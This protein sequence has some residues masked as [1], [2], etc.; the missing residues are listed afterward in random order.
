MYD[1]EY[2]KITKYN[3]A[4][5]DKIWTGIVLLVKNNS[6]KKYYNLFINYF[7]SRSRFI[8]LFLI[9]GIMLLNIYDIINSHLFL[10]IL[11]LTGIAVTY[12]ITLQEC[13]IIV[14]F[15]EN[16]CNYSN[17]TSCSNTKQK[18]SI[19]VKNISFSQLGFV[20]FVGNSVCLL[21]VILGFITP[22]YIN[23]LYFEYQ[24]SLLFIIW[25][26]FYQL[27]ISKKICPLCMCVN[28]IL[29]VNI[30]HFISIGSVF[31]FPQIKMCICMS[32][33]YCAALLFQVV[34][35][36]NIVSKKEAYISRTNELSIKRNKQIMGRYFSN[37][38]NVKIDYLKDEFIIGNTLSELK[39]TLVLSEQCDYCMNLLKRIIP[40]MKSDLYN[41]L[42]IIRFRDADTLKTIKQP[43]PIYKLLIE[44]H[45]QDS[46]NSIIALNDWITG[47]NCADIMNRFAIKSFSERTNH[48]AVNT[49]DW[50]MNNINQF[51]TIII[52][53]KKMPEIYNIKDLPIILFGN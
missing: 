24:L 8:L 7:I 5:F 40:F 44:L 32:L 33:I 26:I 19:I 49:N 15:T 39:V 23:L 9:G 21:L 34:I 29:I 2:N 17:Y 42:W 53:D 47:D 14:N 48:I 37:Q 41:A 36:A 52:N 10:L 28:F 20:F 45:R 12:I 35:K 27:A 4:D 38:E 18:S 31:S 30:L 46:K 25:S 6:K 43:Y 50:I 13:N 1:P 22:E 51:P 3:L 16:F 11:N